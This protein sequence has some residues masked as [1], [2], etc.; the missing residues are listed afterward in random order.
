MKTDLN[1]INFF[2]VP[3]KLIEKY[4]CVFGTKKEFKGILKIHEHEVHFGSSDGSIN[5]RVPFGHIDEVEDKIR[6]FE[7]IL[8]L[9]T[10][11]GY[12]TLSKIVGDINEVK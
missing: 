3:G 11:A 2:K 1:Q 5:L 6:I 8:V 4:N 7:K 9:S 10:S 12:I